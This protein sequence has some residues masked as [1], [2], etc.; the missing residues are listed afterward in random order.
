M[1]LQKYET[2]IETHLSHVSLLKLLYE[3]QPL[4]GLLILYIVCDL[5]LAENISDDLYWDKKYGHNIYQRNKEQ[6]FLFFHFSY[7]TLKVV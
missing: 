5:P 2:D 7:T 6:L 1:S 4:F 3:S